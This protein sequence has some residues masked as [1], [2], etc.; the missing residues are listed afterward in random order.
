MEAVEPKKMRCWSRSYSIVTA[1]S[2][3]VSASAKVMITWLGPM[4]S[5]SKKLCD[6]VNP[7]EIHS[8]K[9]TVLFGCT[10]HRH[11]VTIGKEPFTPNCRPVAAMMNLLEFMPATPWYAYTPSAFA[12]N[13]LV[14][15]M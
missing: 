10:V 2:P 3:L 1:F 7:S 12:T 11:A 6:M 15:D 9:V 8:P 5:M 13:A 4:L 14:K